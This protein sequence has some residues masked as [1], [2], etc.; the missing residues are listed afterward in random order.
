MNPTEVALSLPKVDL[1]EK[2]DLVP[3]FQKMG[4]KTLFD[5]EKADLSSLSKQNLFVEKLFQKNRIIWDEKGAEAASATGAIVSTRMKPL[6]EEF[7]ADHPFLFFL[8]EKEYGLIL[9]AGQINS[10]N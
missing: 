9:M 4:I 1:S 2:L 5:A 10:I 6:V 7:K 3:H 8:I